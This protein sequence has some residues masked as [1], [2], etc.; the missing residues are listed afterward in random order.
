MENSPN[1]IARKLDF[2]NIFLYKALNTLLNIAKC[3][4]GVFLFPCQKILLD[5][6]IVVDSM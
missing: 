1:G 3:R 2:C 4:E 5:T 6:A